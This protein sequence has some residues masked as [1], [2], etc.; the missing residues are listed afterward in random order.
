VNFQGYVAWE[1]DVGDWVEICFCRILYV[2]L[3]DRVGGFVYVGWWVSMAVSWCEC[4]E[5]W[6]RAK[7]CLLAIGKLKVV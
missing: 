5:E 1:R 4:E 2:G 3:I 6:N 7:C